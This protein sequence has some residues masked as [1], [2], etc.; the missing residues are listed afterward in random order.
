MKKDETVTDFSFQFTEITEELRNL[1]ERIEEKEVVCK[2]LRATTPRYDSLTLS[3]E[4]FG[5]LDKM[6]LDEV[7]GSL[8]V[9]EQR[10]KDR[11]SRE[12]DQSLLL[13]ALGKVKK[14]GKT[15]SSLV[16]VVAVAVEREAVASLSN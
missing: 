7:V 4:Q 8:K 5:S 14:E 2:L 10:L 1:G 15:Q 12:E 11:E 13:R 6:N 16:V 3:L 9:H